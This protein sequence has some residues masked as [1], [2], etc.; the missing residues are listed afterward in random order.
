M[1]HF[2]TPGCRIVPRSYSRQYEQL[3]RPNRA[4]DYLRRWEAFEA[5]VA[6]VTLALYDAEAPRHA[7]SIQRQ[8]SEQGRPV[9]AVDAMIAGTALA[10]DEAILTRNVAEF[11][12]TP[13][14]VS[15]Y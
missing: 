1:E 2:A 10:S 6:D 11:S 3:V 14:Q 13:A 12:R 8:L 5:M 9:G 4:N 15:S 7:V